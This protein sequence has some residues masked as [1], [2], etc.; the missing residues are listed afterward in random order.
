MSG[1][2]V[3]TLWFGV[4]TG[5]IIPITLSVGVF[6]GAGA[7]FSTL[8]G[9]AQKM[10]VNFGGKGDG[11]KDN[12]PSPEPPPKGQSASAQPELVR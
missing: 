3:N 7:L 11:Q 8:V 4:V 2:D 1:A 12:S 10:G 6:F 9:A 5:L